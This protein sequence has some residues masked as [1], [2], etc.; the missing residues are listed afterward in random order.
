MTHQLLQF[1]DEL[2]LHND[3]D[4]FAA[5]RAEY[6]RVHDHFM[7]LAEAFLHVVAEVDETVMPLT[8][9]DCV[10]RIYR[11][12]RFSADKRPYKEWLGIFVAA[13]GGKKS[14]RGGYY[15][16][17]Q[18]GQSMFAGGIWCPDKDLLKTLRQEV[19]ANYEEL[20]EI[21]TA[22]T[23]KR[24]F[25]DFDT[26]QMLKRVPAGFDPEFCHAD[27]LKRKAYTFSCRLS[28]ELV[29][30]DKLMDTMHDIVTAAK[31]MNDWLNYVFE[32]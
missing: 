20:E 29:C 13:K 26:D 19:E 12:T 15:L 10:W 22:P 27:W 24:W 5:H 8:P 9:R 1:L 14:P 31:P 16:H 2:S 18:P 25:D 28:D 3:R 11:D 6:D 7:H 23:W 21:M 17:L 30:S 4:W 32:V